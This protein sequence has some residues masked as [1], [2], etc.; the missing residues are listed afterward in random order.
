MPANCVRLGGTETSIVYFLRNR[1]IHTHACVTFRNQQ[2]I[3]L[4]YNQFFA[5]HS[6]TIL[7]Y[8]ILSISFCLRMAFS[9]S[10]IRPALKSSLIS[11]RAFARGVQGLKIC[12][13]LL[14]LCRM[15][16]LGRLDDADAWLALPALLDVADP[17]SRSSKVKVCPPRPELK[18]PLADEPLVDPGVAALSV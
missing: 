15:A 5:P 17:V 1:Q 4:F 18:G 16:R 8:S 10:V 3:N 7:C 14:E 12:A 2:P 11:E 13:S 9:F 6:P